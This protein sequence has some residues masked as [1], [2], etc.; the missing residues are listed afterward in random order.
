[1]SR[2]E[3]AIKLKR[4]DWGGVYST[5]VYKAGTRAA[6]FKTETEINR[7]ESTLWLL[8]SVSPSISYNTNIGLDVVFDLFSGRVFTVISTCTFIR[9][10]NTSGVGTHAHRVIVYSCHVNK[11]KTTSSPAFVL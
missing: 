2:A 7:G 10:R 9:V 8:T 4:F 3:G 1:M 6:N 11:S 5:G